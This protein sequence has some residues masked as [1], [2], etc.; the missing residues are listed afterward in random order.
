MISFFELDKSEAESKM[1]DE[2][3]DPAACVENGLRNSRKGNV[4]C[5]TN[6]EAYH[7][8]SKTFKLVRILNSVKVG[9]DSNTLAII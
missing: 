9:I 3:Y 4:T 1:L 8:E 6:Q 5:S 7:L 2:V